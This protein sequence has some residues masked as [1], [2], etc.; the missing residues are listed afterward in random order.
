V[1]VCELLC[2]I[3]ANSHNVTV[4]GSLEAARWLL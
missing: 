1:C 3:I 4:S 2:L